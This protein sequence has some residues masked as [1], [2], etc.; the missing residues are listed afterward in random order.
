MSSEILSQSDI[1]A[2]LGGG[3]GGVTAA[4]PEV[5]REAQLYDFRRPHRVS[6]D[7]LRTLQAMYDRFA[8]SIEAWLMGRVRDQVE[9]TLQSV[10]QLSF[11][12]FALSLPTPCCSFLVDV[13]NSGGEQG[14][15]D[16]GH[17][18]GC[19]LVDRM[20]GGRGS[21]TVLERALTPIER[22]VIRT[23]AERNAAALQDVWSD[24]VRMSL[25]LG[26]FESIPEILRATG[27]DSPSLVASIEVNAGGR[28]SLM[29]LC[30]PFTIL[31]SFFA[32]S[33]KPRRTM[34]GTPE[35]REVLRRSNEASLRA[36]NIPVSVRMPEF[37]LPIGNLAGLRPGA[38][39]A[40]T[41]E[42]DS[43]VDVF[44][45]EQH[46]FTGQA[47][48]VGRRLAVRVLDAV[49]PPAAEVSGPDDSPF[50]IDY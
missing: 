6:K 41:L 18:F 8:K 35:E 26:G 20:L 38:V 43:H 37:R 17:E 28:K 23:A 13:E 34:A 25:S 49:R 27:G 1:D 30:L 12:D 5:R 45:N 24:Y 2:L 7:R 39:L 46:R 9:L 47:A 32:D 29:S 44:I 14:V 15:I 4:R 48:R 50:T 40:T 36:S 16:F 21:T 42:V 31:D 10:E 3:G 19:Y 11:G 22:M 33:S